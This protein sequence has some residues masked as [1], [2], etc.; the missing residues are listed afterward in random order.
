VAPIDGAGTILLRSGA[1]RRATRLAPGDADQLLDLRT[2]FADP[3]TAGSATRTPRN[4]LAW[5]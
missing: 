5:D 2:R 4:W 1:T 3:Q